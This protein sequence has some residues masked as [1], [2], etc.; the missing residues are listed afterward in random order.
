MS[1]KLLSSA[2]KL[3]ESQRILLAEQIW[4]SLATGQKAP[5][6]TQEQKAELDRRLERLE[7]TGPIGSSWHDVK[8]RIKK[9][10][11]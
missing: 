5:K 2:L 6:L 9:R 8:K 1:S 10:S 7:R 4:D 3:S 11:V